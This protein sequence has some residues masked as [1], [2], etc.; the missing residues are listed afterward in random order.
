MGSPALSSATRLKPP[1]SMCSNSVWKAPTSLGE[2]TGRATPLWSVMAVVKVKPAADGGAAGEAGPASSVGPPL[3]A[4]VS[5]R[6]RLALVTPAGGKPVE[7]I[8]AEPLGAPLRLASVRTM[9]GAVA[10]TVAVLPVLAALPPSTSWLTRSWAPPDGFAEDAVDEV[11][12][13]GD[14]RCRWRRCCRRRGCTTRRR[15]WKHC[16][17]PGWRW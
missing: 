12:R 8:V 3:L 1:A 7:V 17:R 10:V 14:G 6:P 16:R 15:R 11:D 2:P 4:S 9:F 5:D 13:G